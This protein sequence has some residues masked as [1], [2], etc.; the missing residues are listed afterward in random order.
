MRIAHGESLYSDR[1]SV[2][3]FA[4]FLATIWK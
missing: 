3:G 4:Y 2:G 1:A